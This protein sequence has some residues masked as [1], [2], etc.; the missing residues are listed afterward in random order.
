MHVHFSFMN[1]LPCEFYDNFACGRAPVTMYADLFVRCSIDKTARADLP[2]FHV[3][4]AV[5]SKQWRET[6]MRAP[7]A[8][9]PLDDNSSIVQS[10]LVILKQVLYVHSVARGCMHSFRLTASISPALIGE[11]QQCADFSSFP[12]CL[13]LIWLGFD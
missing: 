4:F 8:I 9:C 10:A 11:Q 5:E 1:A 2:N 7:L 3:E 6:L 12:T 13:F